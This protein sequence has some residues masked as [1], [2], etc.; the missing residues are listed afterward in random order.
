M[1]GTRPDDIAILNSVRVVVDTSAP[2]LP[3]SGM[4]RRQRLGIVRAI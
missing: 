1:P 4:D 2:G 3:T